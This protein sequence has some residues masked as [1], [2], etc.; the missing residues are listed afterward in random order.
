MA[1][2]MLFERV[3]HPESACLTQH[4]RALWAAI[5]RDRPSAHRLLQQLV[6]VA[7]D[8]EAAQ[9]VQTKAEL[10]TALGAILVALVELKPQKVHDALVHEN[11][12]IFD[13]VIWVSAGALILCDV[14]L[15]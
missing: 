4:Q 14:H 2:A 6:A 5:E 9:A 15:G 1:V 10:D 7:R 8:L 12:G 13:I 11:D 3:G